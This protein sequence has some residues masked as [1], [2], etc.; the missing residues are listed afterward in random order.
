KFTFEQQPFEVQQLT[1]E[2][3]ATLQPQASKKGL[4]LTLNF[5]GEKSPFVS[6]DPFRLRQVLYNLLGN[7][8]KFTDQGTVSLTVKFSQVGER[9]LFSFKVKDSG[10]GIPEKD[11]SRVFNQ[12]EQSSE[13]NA[14]KHGGTGLGLSIAKSLVE[15][16]GGMLTV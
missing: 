8:I 11:I 10:I 15:S 5:S 6:G 12:F 7:V 2:V 9:A 16:Q 1:R 13:N 3:I 4:D 14:Q